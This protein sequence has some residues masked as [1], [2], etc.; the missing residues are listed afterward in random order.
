MSH[1]FFSL[2]SFVFQEP[3]T[4]E[5]TNETAAAAAR[6]ADG[7]LGLGLF[8]RRGPPLNSNHTNHNGPSLAVDSPVPSPPNVAEPPVATA[9][10][11]NSA[12]ATPEAVSAASR[13]RLFAGVFGST[14]PPTVQQQASARSNAHGST[15]RTS[16]PTTTLAPAPSVVTPAVGLYGRPPTDDNNDDDDTGDDEGTN[17]RHASPAGM[18]TEYHPSDAPAMTTIKPLQPHTRQPPDGIDPSFNTEEDSSIMIEQH[19]S[20]LEE[21]DNFEELYQAFTKNIR[22]SRDI[23]VTFHDDLL[24]NKVLVHTAHA[25]MILLE[26]E[27]MGFGGELDSVLGELD[28]MIH[29]CAEEMKVDTMDTSA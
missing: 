25:E 16:Q 18:A 22:E 26:Q 27:M 29:K 3:K 4:S 21:T 6:P 5:Q 7:G 28:A 20:A 10:T 24:D 15:P 8:G 12:T 2:S 19:P 13:P 9:T 14:A 1:S 11:T 17:Q 23:A